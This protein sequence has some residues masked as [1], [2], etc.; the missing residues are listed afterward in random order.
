MIVS[1]AELKQRVDSLEADLIQLTKDVVD[2]HWMARRYADGRQSYSTAM[3]NEITRRILR[4]GIKLNP[5]GDGTIWARDAMG[6]GFDRLSDEEAAQGR[7]LGRWDVWHED[8]L[9]QT[10]AAL[11][12]L[13]EDMRSAANITQEPKLR[14]FCREAIDRAERSLRG[15][16]P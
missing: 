2:L 14:N 13:L 7:P 9:A 1:K 3:F 16:Q 15:P 5:T 11:K 12:G 10:R 8:E 4:A 6:R